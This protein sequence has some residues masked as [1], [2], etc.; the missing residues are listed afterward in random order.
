MNDEQYI[1]LT[2]ALNNLNQ[3]TVATNNSVQELK[4]YF[5]KKDKEEEKEKQEAEKQAKEE[6]EI[7]E[8]EEAEAQTKAEQTREAQQTQEEIYTEQLQNINTQLEVT[9]GMLVGNFV[10]DGIICGVLLLTIL[11]NKLN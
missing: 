5:I 1:Q 2:E 9:N 10:T 11:W 4:E 3:N 6:A 8:Q 7:K